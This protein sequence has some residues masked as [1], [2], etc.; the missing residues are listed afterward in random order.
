MVKSV[1]TGGGDRSGVNPTRRND[2]GNEMPDPASPIPF[3]DEGDVDVQVAFAAGGTY[4]P[5][6]HRILESARGT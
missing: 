4:G 3:R 5:D 6:C 2:V 1:Q